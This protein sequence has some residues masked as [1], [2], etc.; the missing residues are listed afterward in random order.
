MT[1]TGSTLL[2]TAILAAGAAGCGSI[3]SRAGSPDP[4]P[5]ASA[6]RQQLLA[7][8]Q[9]WV[10]CM[11]DKGMTRMPDAQ[12]TPDGYLTFPMAD[13]YDWKGD[14]RNHPGVIEACK[15]IEDRYPPNAFRPKDEITAD[16]L[17]KLAEYAKCVRQNGIP[18]FP[19]PNKDGEFDLEGTSLENGIPQAKIDVADQAC[20]HIWDGR[21]KVISPDGGKK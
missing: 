10:K 1:R 12:L 20:K 21:I 15:P 16:D 7:L 4:S 19:D 3:G 9:E 18:E 2:I 5:S 8:G 13:G 17:R 11:R 6:D 14:L